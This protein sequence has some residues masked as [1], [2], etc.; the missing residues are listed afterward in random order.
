MIYSNNIS[1]EILKTDEKLAFIQIERTA[2]GKS[3][4]EA[5]KRAEKIQFGYKLEGNQLILDNYL[6]SSVA[7]KFRD[8]EVIIYIY[9]PEATV[10]KVDESAQHY[11][12]S[13][14]DFFNLH[15]SDDNYIYKVNNS[16]VKCLNCPEDE[17]EYNDV[18]MNIT[19]DIS[20]NDTVV[21]TTVKVNGEVV[22]VKQSS[23][24]GLK[25]NE[26]GI[27]IKE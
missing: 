13:D 5:K 15:Y 25:V 12:E 9:L 10:F 19:E 1:F 17:N 7:E 2:R 22:T 26:N 3:F 14:N 16:Q 21:T 6:L 20:D 8:Q 23:K 24:K 18:D 27:I 11:D 4:Q